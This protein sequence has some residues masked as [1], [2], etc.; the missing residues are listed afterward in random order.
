MHIPKETR[1]KGRLKAKK[2]K[3]LG[4]EKGSK[5]YSFLDGNKNVVISTNFCEHENW[6]RVH[7][8]CQVYI[9]IR[10]REKSQGNDIEPKEEAEES[11][12]HSTSEEDDGEYSQAESEHVVKEETQIP[13]R[14]ERAN[15]GIPPTRFGVR[16]INII[17]RS[18]EF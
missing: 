1:R 5:A 9:S 8:N 14:S 10:E 4:Y 7:A 3:F 12:S 13:R 16:E 15:K 6:D 17:S 2:I 18:Q 11:T